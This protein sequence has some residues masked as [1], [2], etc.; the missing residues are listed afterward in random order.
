MCF[1]CRRQMIQS[2]EKSTQFFTKSNRGCQLRLFLFRFRRVR[3]KKI[4]KYV[5]WDE[6]VYRVKNCNAGKNK[7]GKCMGLWECFHVV[8]QTFQIFNIKIRHYLSNVNVGDLKCE[9]FDEICFVK[10]FSK[11]NLNS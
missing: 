9:I 1:R 6:H 8:F 2:F 4:L 5:V 11:L 10:Q 3:R 7:S